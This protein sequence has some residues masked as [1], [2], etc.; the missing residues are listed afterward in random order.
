MQIVD[1]VPLRQYAPETEVARYEAQPHE[2]GEGNEEPAREL[3]WHGRTIR[4]RVRE[5]DPHDRAD[6]D[7]RESGGHL[8][9]SLAQPDP[10]RRWNLLRVLERQIDRLGEALGV[11][12]AANRLLVEAALDRGGETRWNGWRDTGDGRR[13]G[14]ELL[15]HDVGAGLSVE[16]ETAGEGVVARHAERVEITARIDRL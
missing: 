9:L 15:A 6:A 12:I 10:Q 13:G 14:R 5:H 3:E 8:L 2:R 11:A 16:R 4:D 1:V 7:E